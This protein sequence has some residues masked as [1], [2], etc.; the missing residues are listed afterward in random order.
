LPD[1]ALPAVMTDSFPDEP[2]LYNLTLPTAPVL[3]L[4][5]FAGVLPEP[6]EEPPETSFNFSEV[7]YGSPLNTELKEK[8]LGYIM[9]QTRTNLEPSIE[10]QQWDQFREDQATSVKVGVAAVK[11]SYARAGWAEPTGSEME[12]VFSIFEK[13]AMGDIKRSREI[14]KEQLKLEQE[15][16]HFNI[17]K[18]L[19]YEGQLINLHNEVQQRSLEAAIFTI[20]SAVALYEIKVEYIKANIA[21]FTTQAEVYA[22]R[23]QAEIAKVE[24]FKAQLKG[25]K[26]LGKLNKQDIDLYKA[27]IKAV[28][29]SFELYKLELMGIKTQIEGDSLKVQNFGVAIKAFAAEVKAK[30][31]EF[32]G[33]T[34][35]LT[36]EEIKA[37]IYD[38]LVSAYSKEVSAYKAEVGAA[39]KKLEADIKVNV[40][41]PIEISKQSL[42]SFSAL[43]DAELARIDAIVDHNKNET[44]LFSAE[45]EGENARIKSAVNIYKSEVDG[46]RSTIE[47]DSTIA[48]AKNAT[49]KATAKIFETQASAT[50]DIIKAAVSLEKNRVE[51][52][53]ININ[54]SE[55]LGLVGAEH[56]QINASANEAAGRASVTNARTRADIAN[57][58]AMV[59][60]A[61]F[62]EQVAIARVNA[63]QEVAANTRLAQAQLAEIQISAQNSA[64]MVGIQS[65][66]ETKTWS[67]AR[68]FAKSNYSS[69]GS[70]TRTTVHSG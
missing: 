1:H 3:N 24:I 45:V 31:L 46:F 59:S 38:S 68:S 57:T 4:V 42:D 60:G 12:E 17:G 7:A 11:R 14:T 15:N 53:N 32:D 58:A 70:T 29:A 40:T 35:A 52:A 54:R 33:Y 48:L 56:N 43:V 20:D 8:F 36:G 30:A 66:S 25:L 18:A 34:T 50:S 49:N 2:S 16:L 51:V 21:L 9:D 39:A 55:A 13:S 63:M 65:F 28:V 44:Q 69:G 27:R 6:L 41:A 22:T 19:E 23:I 47:R 62:R 64:A 37:K 61:R 67:Q 10:Q 26:L 5:E